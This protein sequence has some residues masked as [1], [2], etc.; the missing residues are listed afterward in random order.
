MNMKRTFLLLGLSMLMSTP[1]LAVVGEDS[2]KAPNEAVGF[3]YLT[4][5]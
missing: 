5:L 4:F 2:S 1:A 3:G